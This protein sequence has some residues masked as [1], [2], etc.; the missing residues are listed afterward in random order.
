MVTVLITG[1]MGAGKS[2]VLDFIRSKGYATFKA[3]QFARG[4]LDLK[5]PYFK[6]LIEVLG[7]SFITKDS[8]DRRLLAQK[9]FQNK[10]QLREVEKII[11]PLVR[12]GFEDFVEEQ[13]KN[14]KK[15]VFYEVPLLSQENFKDRF[16]HVILVQCPEKLSLKRLKKKGFK[17]E[18][19][20]L[21]WSV[22]VKEASVLDLVDFI[23]LNDGD[24]KSL[25]QQV[26]KMLM[27]LK[28]EIK[29]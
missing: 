2:C 25:K 21:R 15:V 29:E 3:D 27:N 26:E 24:I 13:K 8:L 11:H 18:E 4:L 10:N 20:Y 23:I 6:G 17:E 1:R 5:S 16:D 14:S 22:Q 9:L 28:E 19:I 7:T 12:K